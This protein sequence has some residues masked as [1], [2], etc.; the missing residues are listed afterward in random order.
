[1]HSD[2]GTLDVIDLISERHVSLRKRTEELWNKS[3]DLPISN[4]EWF[5]IARIYK[6]MPT[7]STLSRQIDISRQ[8]THKLIKK[9]ESK[10]LVEIVQ[11]SNKKEKCIQLTDLGEQCYQKNE[12]LKASLESR[13]KEVI[14]EEHLSSLKHILKQDWGL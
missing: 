11:S 6:K 2:L 14:G 12:A 10:G 9:M 3:H 5:I 4:S 13:I 1:M 8:G 7:I